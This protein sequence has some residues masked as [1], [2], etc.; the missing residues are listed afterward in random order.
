M[1]CDISCVTVDKRQCNA[2]NPAYSSGAGM[3]SAHMTTA[4]CRLLYENEIGMDHSTEIPAVCAFGG[5]LSTLP[6]L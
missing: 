5:R 2:V 6:R 3:I 1:I 4:T